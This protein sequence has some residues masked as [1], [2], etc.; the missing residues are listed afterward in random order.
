MP[1]ETR[2]LLREVP[3]RDHLGQPEW[4]SP[5]PLRLPVRRHADRD[6]L[7]PQPEERGSDKPSEQRGAGRFGQGAPAATLAYPPEQSPGDGEVRH[8][9]QHLGLAAD[10]HQRREACQRAEPAGRLEANHAKYGEKQPRGERLQ[11]HGPFVH[12]Q[13]ERGGEH[14]SDSRSERGSRRGSQRP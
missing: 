5:D 7:Q 13:D 11:V 2:S 10:A 4:I 14:E 3:E 9:D 12:P 1:S 8:A 6:V